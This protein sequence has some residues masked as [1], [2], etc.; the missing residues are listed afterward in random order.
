MLCTYRVTC[1]GN[2]EIM[3]AVMLGLPQFSLQFKGVHSNA[4]PLEKH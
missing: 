1:L 4:D 3:L 2:T